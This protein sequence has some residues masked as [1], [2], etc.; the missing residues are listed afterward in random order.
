MLIKHS[1]RVSG[2]TEIA[3]TLLDVLSGLET[4]KICEYYELDGKRI[5][6]IPASEKDFLAA[7]PVYLEVPG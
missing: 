1:A 4:I 5:E 3:I 7:K 2:L 6:S